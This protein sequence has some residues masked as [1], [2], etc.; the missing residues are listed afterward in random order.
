M[1]CPRDRN[2]FPN[3]HNDLAAAAPFFKFDRF[4]CR[5]SRLQVGRQF[6]SQGVG[7]ASG[8]FP[9]WGCEM[10][11]VLLFALLAAV[12]IEDDDWQEANRVTL[13]L[14]PTI[15]DTEGTAWYVDELDDG[16]M[17]A[18]TGRYVLDDSGSV[19]GVQLCFTHR[20]F[21][22]RDR[23]D[24]PRWQFDYDYLTMSDGRYGVLAEFE[25]GTRGLDCSVMRSFEIDKEGNPGDPIPARKFHLVTGQV[26]KLQ[27]GI[28]PKLA[29]TPPPGF[30]KRSG[31]ANRIREK[32]NTI[33]R[34][35]ALEKDWYGWAVDDDVYVV[36]SLEAGHSWDAG[37]ARLLV[38]CP[39]G[40]YVSARGRYVI[41]LTTIPDAIA[42]ELR[43]TRHY[44]AEDD[45]SSLAWVANDTSEEATGLTLC[46]PLDDRSFRDEIFSMYVS[47]TYFVTEG[48]RK[49]PR[50][51]EDGSLLRSATEVIPESVFGISLGT[52][53]T[54]RPGG[55]FGANESS[56]RQEK[57][58]LSAVTADSPP[59][60][61][62]R[63]RQEV[64][65]VAKPT[66]ATS[67]AID[68][69]STSELR[70]FGEHA[71]D[72]GLYP[73][74][75]KAYSTL[76]A[77]DAN[78][79]HAYAMRGHCY[80][81]QKQFERAIADYDVLIRLKPTVKNICHRANAN[82][83]RGQY[84]AVVQDYS[85]A[86]QLDP[87]DPYILNAVAWI[88]A[89]CPDATVRNGRRAETAARRACDL[90]SYK[91]PNYVDT[92]AAAYAETGD[93]IAAVAFQKDACRELKGS[94]LILAQKRL[95]AY[96]RR[97]PHREP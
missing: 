55:L 31:S 25:E 62:L 59:G 38:V 58:I 21:Q 50:Y 14:R 46:V 23:F 94:D 72:K 48:G 35:G 8:P 73:D 26:L 91:E 22:T 43:M 70:D 83:K 67:N 63:S 87:S 30:V 10:S 97:E 74:A 1:R 96:Q 77:N 90:T 51:N 45:G 16:E 69:L 92:L 95:E 4:T 64:H 52:T 81:A 93:F 39:G 34:T 80:F 66:L 68:G 84:R 7:G 19:P 12:A 57:A 53:F 56:L 82:E 11:F 76:I 28:T 24:I 32:P 18:F 60:F 85:Q 49:A 9:S 17:N 54:V 88:W 47:E 29:W 61:R 44:Y 5:W 36:L 86:Y 42:I 40:W 3:S 78:D 41:N 6:F 15:S 33:Y 71:Y 89:T 37:D 27:K 13:S 75:L 65:L 2:L 79:W 20:W